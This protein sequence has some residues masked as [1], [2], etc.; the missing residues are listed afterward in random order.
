MAITDNTNIFERNVPGSTE[1]LQKAV[2]G[3]AGCGGLGSNAAAALV[4]AG[5]GRLILVDG[6]IVE[7]SNLNRQY[8]FTKDIGRKKTLALA[9]H[10]K[11]INPAVL[12]TLIDD[13]IGPDDVAVVFSD[14]AIL[15]EAFDSAESKSWLLEAWRSAF[16]GRPV[17]CASGLAG[18]GKSE[19]IAVR[20]SG[21]IYTVGDNESDMSMGLCSA[22]VAIA[23][24]MEANVAIEL[25]VNA[26]H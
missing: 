17:V 16:P 26:G 14:A 5:V 15:I 11:S 6:D 23:A 13:R 4:R 22:R 20:R 24:N 18:L 21:N 1:I 10:L 7:A 8:Y 12:L 19:S 9:R 25:L 2:V 3:I